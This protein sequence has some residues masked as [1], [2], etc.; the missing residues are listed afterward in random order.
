MVQNLREQGH[1]DRLKENAAKRIEQNVEDVRQRQ[2]NEDFNQDAPYWKEKARQVKQQNVKAQREK[3]QPQ[4]PLN[5]LKQGS[6]RLEQIV[7]GAKKVNASIQRRHPR[8]SQYL[9]Q[10]FPRQSANP[11]GDFGINVSYPDVVMDR[12][13]KKRRGRNQTVDYIE[14][15]NSLPEGWGKLF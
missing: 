3:A 11:F 6:G 13:P 10:Q 7:R 9:T 8:A 5:P 14:H 12:T 15:M 1:R 4:K 2:W